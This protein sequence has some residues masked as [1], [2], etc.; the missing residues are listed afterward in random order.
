MQ[1][2]WQQQGGR[3]GG[4]EGGGGGGEP[5]MHV[6]L[7]SAA[8]GEWPLLAAAQLP[9]PAAAAIGGG[10]STLAAAVAAPAALRRRLG[11]VAGPLAEVEPDM[12]MVFGGDMTLAGYPPWAARAA[13]LFAAGPLARASA[14]RLDDA[15]RRFRS[16]RQRW[17]R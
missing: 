15:L 8:D 2:G 6:V 5:R 17:G 16:T 9:P 7:L 4:G 3:E 1:A 12:V 11:E 13:E 14:T 10:S